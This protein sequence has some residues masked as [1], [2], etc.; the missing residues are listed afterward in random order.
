MAAEKKG[1][2]NVYNAKG[3]P[4]EHEADDESPEFK[5]G[6]RAK[7]KAGGLA[8]GGKAAMR[9]DKKPRHHR[10][11]GGKTP[12]SSGHNVSDKETGATGHESERPSEG[13]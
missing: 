2:M 3:S 1:K 6:G 13:G 4:E 5:K 11:M 12:Y 7:R 9:M 10:A 8:E